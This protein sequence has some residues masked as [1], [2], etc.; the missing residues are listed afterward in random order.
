MEYEFNHD[1][2]N[3]ILTWTAVEGADAYVVE[4][5]GADGEWTPVAPPV[6]NPETTETTWE[7][8]AFDFGTSRAFRVVAKNAYGSSVGSDAVS[9][10]IQDEPTVVTSLEDG[11]LNL[12]DGVT[13]LREALRFAQDGATITFAEDLRGGTITLTG[14]PLSIMEKEI[15]VN[16]FVDETGAPELTIDGD[17]QDLIVVVANTR[18]SFFGLSV[19]TGYA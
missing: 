5:L 10:T 19:V 13:T 7:S 1:A 4:Q 12:L 11:D 14:G 8:G 17:H 18:A 9:F 6:G 2:K 15:S 16:G 3:A